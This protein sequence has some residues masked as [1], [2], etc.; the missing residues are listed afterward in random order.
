MS[1]AYIISTMASQAFIRGDFFFLNSHP[2]GIALP[3]ARCGH[4]PHAGSQVSTSLT[5]SKGMSQ[6]PTSPRSIP[7]RL[8]SYKPSHEYM[9]PPLPPLEETSS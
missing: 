1:A 8:V 7:S 3:H 4:L 2:N 6:I 5:S 9:H